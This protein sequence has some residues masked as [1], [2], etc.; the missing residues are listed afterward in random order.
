MRA[1][2]GEFDQRAHDEEEQVLRVKAVSVHEKYHYAL[3]LSYD[4]ALIELDQHI[5][6]GRL[7]LG[8]R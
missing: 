4:I 2:V 3:P 1:V 6:F 8:S 7:H 5:Q